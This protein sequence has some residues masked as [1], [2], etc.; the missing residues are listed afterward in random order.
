[1]DEPEPRRGPE[2]SRRERAYRTLKNRLLEGRYPP[3]ARL[4]EV[5]LAQEL[6]VSRQTIG[7]ILVR[8]EHDGLIV[9]HANRGAS[10]RSVGIAEALRIM[11]LREAL[12][13][14]AAV[15]AAECASDDQLDE[16][17]SIAAQMRNADEA[18]DL[19]RYADLCGRLHAIVL[20]AASEPRLDQ[21]LGSLNH[22]LL[23]YEYRTMLLSDRKERS[24]Q[25]HCE[26]VSA[27]VARDG[28]AAESAMRRHVSAV[29]EALSAGAYLLG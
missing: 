15:I 23:R 21:M 7:L 13:G 4:V 10:V 9:A 22:A 14:V 2:S 8:L 26:I 17:S 6:S 3:N 27:L 5:E 16:L 24:V 1:V 29:R 20:E 18:Q 12:E 19:L 25:E 11:R 28:A